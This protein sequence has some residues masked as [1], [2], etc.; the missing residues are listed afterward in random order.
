MKKVLVIEDNVDL[1]SN[2]AELLELANYEVLVA[3]DSNAGLIMAINDN[4][5]I[6]ICDIM[7]PGRDGYEILNELK[8]HHGCQ[9]IAF[10]FLTSRSEKNEI[11]KGMESGADG[12]ITKPFDAQDLLNILEKSIRKRQDND[13]T[14]SQ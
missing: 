9:D 12:Y 2:T 1:R 3:A 5:D 6:I 13:N 8:Q 11:R 14:F 10:I 4:P 7:M